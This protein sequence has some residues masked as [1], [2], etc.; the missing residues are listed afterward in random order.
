M[1]N[2]A[3]KSIDKLYLIYE[4][5]LPD[6]I[7]N[8]KII[9]IQIQSRPTFRNMFDIISIH[10]LSDDINI[11]CNTDCFIDEHDT[12]KLNNITGQDDALC[13]LR[14]EIK[15]VC[16]L[17]IDARSS[18]KNRIKHAN[19]MQDCWI[20]RGKPKNEMWLDFPMGVPG[21]D[22]RLA[23]E[24][25]KAGYKLLNPYSIIKVYHYHRSKI[26]RYSDDNR[27]QQPYAFPAFI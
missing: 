26:R 19:D 3:N 18:K 15:S 9:P 25:Q 20:I 17:K 6:S 2:V 12:I 5:G 1:Q 22:N 27:V 10:S 4:N 13:L 8:E 21:C 14:R 11:I 23:F 24:M 16:P 7:S